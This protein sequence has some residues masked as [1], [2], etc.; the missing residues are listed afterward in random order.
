MKIKKIRR[1]K[2]EPFRAEYVLFFFCCSKIIP[3]NDMNFFFVFFL[4]E[5]NWKG[6]NISLEGGEYLVCCIRMTLLSFS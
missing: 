5:R 4:S 3:R 1:G 2:K 6:V